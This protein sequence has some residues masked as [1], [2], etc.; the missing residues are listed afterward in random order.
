MDKPEIAKPIPTPTAETQA[1][2]QAAANG[3]LMLQTC[4]QCQTLQSLPRPFCGACQS[5]ALSWHEAS[6]RGT[7]I[8][9]SWVER[10]P[11]KAFASPYMLALIELEEGVR[12]M[13]NIIGDNAEQ[14]RIGDAVE[15]V[16]EARGDEGFQLPQAKLAR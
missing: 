11:T 6:G 12:L 3:K 2:W 4:N 14:A 13:L 15:I 8:S 7:V 16:F 5:E 9:Y 10:G 1:Y